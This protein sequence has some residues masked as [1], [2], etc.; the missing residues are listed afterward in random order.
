MNLLAKWGED[1]PRTEIA[2]TTEQQTLIEIA[3]A[4]LEDGQGIDLGFTFW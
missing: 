1:P 2:R 3:L 4:M